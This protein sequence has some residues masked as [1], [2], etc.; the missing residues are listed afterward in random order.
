VKINQAKDVLLGQV[1][2]SGVKPPPKQKRRRA[3]RRPE[4]DASGPTN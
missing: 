2:A 4:L 3:S 1:S